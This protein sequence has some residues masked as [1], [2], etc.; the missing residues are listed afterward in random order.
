MNPGENII[1]RKSV[2]SAVTIPHDQTFRNIDRVRPEAGTPDEYNF[3]F[4][5]KFV[6]INQFATLLRTPK[7][8][9]PFNEQVADGRST[10]WCLVV[11][12][13]TVFPANYLWCSPILKMTV[14][15][16]MSR[17]RAKMLWPIVASETAFILISVPWAIPSIACQEKAAIG[18]PASWHRTCLLHNSKSFTRTK[19]CKECLNLE[20]LLFSYKYFFFIIFQ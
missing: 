20:P 8:Y 5:G 12:L 11:K 9:M 3:N 17:E 14:W 10:C 6:W 15:N 13:V 16:R 4:C 19:L 1:R 18:W 2:E 7:T